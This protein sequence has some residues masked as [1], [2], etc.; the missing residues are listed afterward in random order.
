MRE[1]GFTLLEVLVA[2]VIMAAAVVA[3]LSN[4]STSLNNASRLT[5]YDRAVIVAR[6]TMNE[7]LTRQDLPKMTVMEG[8]WDRAA[9]G[10]EGGWR[11]RL[12]P[13]ERTPGA[14]PG[15]WGLDRLELEVWWMNGS[16]RQS[17]ELEAFR[18]TVLRPDDLNFGVVRP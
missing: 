10:V 11:A 17:L 7:L 13:F 14:G 5:S 6:N 15:A 1:R 18:S 9:V 3:L 4:L 16:Q 8:T 12:M 2:T